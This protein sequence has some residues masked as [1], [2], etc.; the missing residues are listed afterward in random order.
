VEILVISQEIA[1][2]QNENISIAKNMDTSQS[3]VEPKILQTTTKQLINPIIILILKAQ[4][5]IRDM[6]INPIINSTIK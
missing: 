4:T 6:K 1:I 2:I 3:I 5:T